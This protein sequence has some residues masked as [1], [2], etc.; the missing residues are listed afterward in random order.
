MSFT[1]LFMRYNHPYINSNCSIIINHFRE[2]VIASY[3]SAAASNFTK[4]IS[5]NSHLYCC[6]ISIFLNFLLKSLGLERIL[7]ILQPK[8]N[9]K[10]KLSLRQVKELVQDS[11]FH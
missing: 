11:I 9:D 1:I 6:H 4:C 7:E 8:F 3:K 10:K 5:M 2:H